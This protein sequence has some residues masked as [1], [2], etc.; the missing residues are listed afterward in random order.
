MTPKKLDL[1][2]KGLK[3]LKT[4]HDLM[5]SLNERVKTL[6]NFKNDNTIIPAQDKISD[7]E[8]FF[9]AKADPIL[10]KMRSERVSDELK[11]F[12]KRH[13]I[14]GMHFRYDKDNH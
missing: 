8:V 10:H 14:A 7:L 3:E 6:E 5:K 11:E 2:I 1:L 9:E 13:R 4:F 12:I